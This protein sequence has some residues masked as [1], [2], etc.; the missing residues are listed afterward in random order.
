MPKQ[1]LTLTYGKLI[2]WVL[3]LIHKRAIK[4]IDLRISCSRTV[5]TYYEN[6]FI[7]F[8][9]VY[10][11]LPLYFE[12]TYFSQPFHVQKKNAKSALNLEQDAHV[13]IMVGSL[14]ERKNPLF[15]LEVIKKLL[16]EIPI[17]CLFWVM[18]N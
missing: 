9:L 2:G 16:R 18:V 12:E 17:S 15:C 5:Q 1:E 3:T 13:I 11:C 7:K 14:N 8:K 6:S 4:K 10:N